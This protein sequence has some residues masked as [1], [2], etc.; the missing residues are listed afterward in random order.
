MNFSH[1]IAQ[2]VSFS[3]NKSFTKVIVRFAIISIALSLAT[4]ILTVSIL[5][6]FQKEISSK[7]YGFWGHIHITDTNINRS[8]EQIPIDKRAAYIDEIRDI[9]GIE[10]EVPM[11]IWGI[12][13]G[14]RMRTVSSKGG[15]HHVQPFAL[16]PGII[17]TQ[18]EFG[19]ILLKG[20]DEEFDWSYHDDFLDTGKPIDL[21]GALTEDIIISKITSNK[22]GLDVG[23]R[24]IISFV[25]GKRQTKKRFQVKG[26]YNTGLEEYDDRFAFVDLRRVQEILGWQEHQVSGIEIF[27][28]DVEDVQVINEYLYELVPIKMYTE[29]ITAKYPAIFEWLK[30]QDINMVVIL[31]L[32]VIVAVINM[33]TALLI[34]ILERTNMVGTLKSLGASNWQIR[35]VFLINAGY[36]ILFGLL[37]GN[38]LGLSLCFLQDKFHFIKLDE[39]NYYLSYAPVL[40]STWKVILLNLLCFITTVIFLIIP[41]YLV[42]K[43]SPVKAL[44][45]G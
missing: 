29:T 27:L 45:F 24:L 10:Y 3:K 44:R 21:T 6:G 2:R 31:I 41:S 38:I 28:D 5:D 17:N 8:F 18:N 20:I 9:G 1:F 35:K 25:K 40:I 14:D 19:G 16:A 13:L 7:V 11:E 4:M 42:T 33:I 23:D 26:I 39:A 30:L 37:I 22:Y 36:I 32:M 34:L 12:P 15:V 43:I